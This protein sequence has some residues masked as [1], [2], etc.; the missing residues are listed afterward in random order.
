MP[1]IS[2]GTV[3]QQLKTWLQKQYPNVEFK[4]SGWDREREVA[5]HIVWEKPDDPL[6]PAVVTFLLE[7]KT[8]LTFPLDDVAWQRF[9]SEYP[10][11]AA[12]LIELLRVGVRTEQTEVTTGAKSRLLV[13][14]FTHPKLALRLIR[15]FSYVNPANDRRW[16]AIASIEHRL[17]EL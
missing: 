8:S 13:E 11:K 4:L 5:L 3:A 6:P 14:I 9:S 2:W 7:L 10:E 12:R 15:R 17:E 16:G 1:E